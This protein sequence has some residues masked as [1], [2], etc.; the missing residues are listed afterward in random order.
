MEQEVTLPIVYIL[1]D[2][3]TRVASCEVWKSLLHAASQSSKSSSRGFHALTE[4]QS[5]AKVLPGSCHGCLTFVLFSF[6]FFFVFFLVA[7]THV[8]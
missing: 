4:V 5:G 6:C 1:Y 3:M 8:L 7:T 2:H